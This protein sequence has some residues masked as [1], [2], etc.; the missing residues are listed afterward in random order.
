MPLA[1]SFL[2]TKIPLRLSILEGC[3]AFLAVHDVPDC[4]WIAVGVVHL[5]EWINFMADLVTQARLRMPVAF[6]PT[7]SGPGILGLFDLQLEANRLSLA[8]F[9]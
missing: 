2:T 5:H 7:R 3:H 8:H 9:V 4:F 6:D 1:I